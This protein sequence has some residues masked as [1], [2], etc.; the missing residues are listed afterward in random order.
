MVI[1]GAVGPAKPLP[2]FTAAPPW[3][4]WFVQIHLSPALAPIIPWI[5]VLLGATGLA[6]GLIAIRQGWRP[7]HK[8]LIAGS[9]VAVF[10]LMVVP[11][12]ASGDPLQYYAAYGRIALLGHSPYVAGSD[13]W[14]AGD[15][16]ALSIDQVVPKIVPLPPSGYGPAATAS[17]E[18]AAALGGNS[19]ARILFWLKVWNAVAYLVLVLVLD[20]L[21]RSDPARRVRVH[22]M[23]S[24]NPLMLFLLMAD[25]H[26]DVLGAALGATAL[27]AMRKSTVSRAFRAG[28][29]LVLAVAVKATYAMFGAGVLW[30]ARRSPRALAALASGAVAVLIPFC[31]VSGWSTLTAITS[32]LVR[33]APTDLLWHDLTRVVPGGHADAV[34]NVV[35]LLA[36]VALALVLL[37][38][39]PSGPSDLPGVR[40]ALALI[41]AFLIA[42]PYLQAWYDAMLFPLLAVMLASRLDWIALAQATALSI[43]SVLYFYPSHPSLWSLLERYGTDVPYTVTLAASVVALLWLCWTRNWGQIVPDELLP[44]VP[45]ASG[46]PVASKETEITGPFGLIDSD[47][48]GEERAVTPRGMHS[49]PSVR[50]CSR[51]WTNL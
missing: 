50:C 23:W 9:V 14:L 29:L 13:K 2:I 8:R 17:E 11:P 15:P 51:T 25:G 21:M 7:S 44:G 40:E 33:G 18:A 20:R 36:C 32:S 46:V 3:P 10:A 24:V 28:V 12:V 41:L 38:R 42:S 49:T 39:L 5:A 43:D 37:R 27:F 48:L 1:R 30:A 45:A 47:L 34:T 22:L 4:P 19:P 6:A 31:L 35:G 26:N 16:I